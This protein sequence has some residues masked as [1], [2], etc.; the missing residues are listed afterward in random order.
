MVKEIVK[1]IFFLFLARGVLVYVT[2]GSFFDVGFI[3]LIIG[4]LIGRIIFLK[5]R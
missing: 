4:S 2:K 3:G 1:F 5:N